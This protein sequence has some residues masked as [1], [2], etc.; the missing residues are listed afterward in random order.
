MSTASASTLS[1]GATSSASTGSAA[2]AAS[3]LMHHLHPNRDGNYT[4]RQLSHANA[5]NLHLDPGF[6]GQVDGDEY[7]QPL[8]VDRG[9]AAMTT[10]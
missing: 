2:G 3:V 10:W 1:S 7:A 5:A 8:F 9:A 4:D 6:A